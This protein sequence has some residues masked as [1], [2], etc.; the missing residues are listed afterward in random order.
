MKESLGP[1]LWRIALYGLL[2]GMPPIVARLANG[3]ST[4]PPAVRLADNLALLAFA[5]LVMQFVLSARFRWIERPFGLDR[6]FVFHKVMAVAAVCLLL[7]HPILLAAGQ[8][9]LTLLTSLKQPW[10]VLVGKAALLLLLAT[11]G[12]SLFR[13]TLHLEYQRWRR[14]HNLLALAVLSAAGI[15]SWFKG[16]D[17]R[18]SQTMRLLWL[19]LGLVGLIAYLRHLLWPRIAAARHLCHVTAVKQE[20]P[21]IWTLT[22]APPQGAAIPAYQPGQFHF[23]TLKRGRG[24][25]AEE[26]P[27]SIASS[28]LESG[29]LSSTLKEAGDFT[30]TIGQTRIGD[31][32]ILEGPFGRFSLTCHPNLEHLVFIAAGIGITPL[33]SMLRYLR[34]TQSRQPVLLLYANRSEPDIVFRE[35][36]E[37]MARAGAPGL[38]LVHVL[39]RPSPQWAGETGR[40]DLARLR[41]H[42]ATNLHTSSFYICAPPAMIAAVA[43]DLAR[44]GV[45]RRHIHF[46]KFAL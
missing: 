1:R 11:V 29:G 31:A 25:P 4:D 6:L 38:Q 3:P 21:H 27:F 5:I 17:L 37:G 16:P 28:P 18:H 15:H 34:D 43:R 45:R 26:H 9:G 10:P 44:L 46:E 42:C 20:A 12:L 39:S 14:L 7:A 32:A 13:A 22:F 33:M 35:E 41:Q 19:A 24:L 23:V 36:L 40:I 8:S 2:I 30:R